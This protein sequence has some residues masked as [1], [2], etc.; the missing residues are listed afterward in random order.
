MKFKTQKQQKGKDH[1]IK[2]IRIER[3]AKNIFIY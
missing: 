2:E 3:G 1:T